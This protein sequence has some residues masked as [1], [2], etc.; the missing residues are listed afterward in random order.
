MTQPVSFD[1]TPEKEA[2]KLEFLR[3]QLFVKPAVLSR[4]DI[5]L[6]GQTAVVTGANGGIGLECCRQLLGL[7]LSKLILAVRDE[8]KGNDARTSLV[9]DTNLVAER[10]IEVWKLDYASYESIVSFARRA[11]QTLPSLSIAILNAGINR[12]SFSINPLTGHE[13]DI[14]TNY[15]SCALLTFLLLRVF[16][17][18]ASGTEPSQCS[19][20]RL[21][22]VSSDTAAWAQFTERDKQPLLKALDDGTAKW[23]KYERY[24]TSKLLGQLF[25]SELA[26]RVPRSLAVVNCA[27]PGLCYSKLHRELSAAVTLPI[28]LIG[29]SPEIGARALL[30]A[31]VKQDE[32]SHGQYVED[33]QLRPMAPF[34]YSQEGANVAQRLWDETL[35]ELSFAAVGD[36]IDG[37]V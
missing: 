20:G 13:D 8:V 31:A 6:D 23:D 4:S 22:L 21:V 5:D 26:K 25:V 33:G 7:G 35:H 32:R 17:Q 18:A 27:N 9:N 15:L 1:I 3:R 28:R 37:L 30:H 36:I 10:I 12:A 34:V 11:E 24:G 14:Q 16:K 29:R 19:A 2:S